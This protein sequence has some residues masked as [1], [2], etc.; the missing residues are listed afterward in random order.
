MRR[1]GLLCAMAL[2]LVL[3]LNTPQVRADEPRY[4]LGAGY[5][6]PFRDIPQGGTGEST[7]YFYSAYGN[8]TCYVTISVD[9]APPGWKVEYDPE[10]V[11]VEPQWF[12]PTPFELGPGQ[13][14]I[15]LKYVENGE[16]KQG[17]VRAWT[18]KVKVKVPENEA[19]G[20]YTVK[21]GYV[22]DWRMGGMSAVKR[23]GSSE[24][25]IKVVEQAV[26]SGGGFSSIYVIILA[27]VFTIPAMIFTR[28]KWVPAVASLGSRLRKIHRPTLPKFTLSRPRHP[29]KKVAQKGP[30]L[31]DQLKVHSVSQV[32]PAVS[33]AVAEQPQVPGGEPESPPLPL[34]HR[35][36]MGIDPFYVGIGL[37]IA[38]ALLGALIAMGVIG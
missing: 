32:N 1:F 16:N 2:L 8:V 9:Q 11:V 27:T 17:Y 35:P 15:L 25:H 36:K 13:E 19:L 6:E 4:N 12:S 24:W 14:S 29:E 7:L 5:V 22:G 21:V 34:G 18:V 33:P 20:T 38:L 31:M 26:G 37:A 28:S 10:L 23:A 3:F 30:G